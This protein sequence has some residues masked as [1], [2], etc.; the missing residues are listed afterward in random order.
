VE[1]SSRLGGVIEKCRLSCT[2]FALEYEDGAHTIARCLKEAINLAALIL[3][4]HKQAMA[5]RQDPPAGGGTGTSTLMADR[6]ASAWRMQ[7][8]L[9]TFPT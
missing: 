6:I 2:R 9:H 4:A 7:A 1:A 3:A 5:G 8:A